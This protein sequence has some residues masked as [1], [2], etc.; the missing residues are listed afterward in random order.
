[1]SQL[2]IV[3]PTRIDV[4]QE[5]PEPVD[6]IGDEDHFPLPDLPELILDEQTPAWKNYMKAGNLLRQS[7]DIFRIAGHDN[8]LL[9]VRRD[10][11]TKV[12]NTA[13]DLAPLFVDRV[14]LSI[15]LGDKPKGTKLSNAHLNAMLK[16]EAFLSQFPVVDGITTVP[17]FLPD[18]TLTKPGY[19][20]GGEGH[21]YVYIGDEPLVIDLTDCTD[22]FLDVMDFDSEADLANTIAAALT[23]MLWNHW[24]GGKPIFIVTA[25]KSHAGK[26]TLILFASGLNGQCSISYQ[27]TD[28]ALERALVGAINYNSDARV[29]VIEN[30]R[31]DRR[32]SS[33]SSAI[34][35]RFATDPNPFLFSTGTGPARRRRNDFVLAIST[36]DGTVSED[37]L[38]RGLPIHLS[39]VGHVAERVSP[40]GNPKL[41]YLPKKR[42]I[43]AA[44]LRGMIERWKDEGMPLDHSARHPFSEWAAT[45]GGILKV[46]GINGFLANYGKRRVADDPVRASIA[47]LGASMAG[48]EWHRP[49]ALTREASN[50]GILKSM[51]S[52]TS[53]ETFESRKR[54]V[55]VVLSAHEGETFAVET[56]SA[57]LKLRLEKGRRR[58][59]GESPHV[60]YRFVVVERTDI[61]CDGD[62]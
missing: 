43:I 52:S 9:L 50:L 61:P 44:E 17:I 57:I 30:A 39:P 18:F 55:G 62:F 37:I 7:G 31:L 20:D 15:Y 38:N 46:S 21:R 45:I 16:A 33:I 47:L 25:S 26:D 23:V 28:W 6:P 13:A 1:M 29:I 59:N 58:F 8:G 24:P 32:A 22:S 51:L 48:D 35:E 53:Q 42:E 11:S 14:A 2:S 54:G 36:N 40:I 12:I 56:D 5:P 3:H 4:D 41:E 60:R 19:N 34:I 49:D 27:S 10:G